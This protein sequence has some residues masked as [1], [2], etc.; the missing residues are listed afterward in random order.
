MQFS[1]SRFSY[2]CKL[3]FAANRKLYLLG[4]AAIAGMMLCYM[5]YATFTFDNGLDVH[6]QLDFASI[7]LLLS[8][9]FFGSL[10]FKQYG[11]KSKRIQ[12]IL[13]PVSNTERMAV[14]VLYTFILYPLVFALLYFGSL[15]LVHTVDVQLLGKRNIIYL[16]DGYEGRMTLM[17][18]CFVQSLALLGAIWFRRFTF[19][20]T[21]VMVCLAGILI[22][23]T[24][25][26]INSIVLKDAEARAATYSASQRKVV[27]PPDFLHF[28]MVN[29]APYQNL[30]FYGRNPDGYIISNEEYWVVLPESQMLLFMVLLAFVPL[31]FFY[32]TAVKLREQ[33][34]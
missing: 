22:S 11:D 9:A 34:L 1:F 13:L 30:K 12:S 19:V 15:L 21:V 10:I 24:N 32:L 23:L 14:A 3:Q 27:Y 4:I 33:Q 7:A 16:P 18:F 28:E 5:F 26:I 31:F 29:S 6:A 2:L 17:L 20:K 8:S 25:D